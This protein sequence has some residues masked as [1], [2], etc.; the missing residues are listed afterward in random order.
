MSKSRNNRTN[1]YRDTDEEEFDYESR[2][3]K[4]DFAKHKI[5]RLMSALKTKDIDTLMD[6]EDD[7]A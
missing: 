4:E 7:Y 3:R 5:K 2:N 6:L 1:F